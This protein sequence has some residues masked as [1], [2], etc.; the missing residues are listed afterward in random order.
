MGLYYALAQ[1]TLHVC[2][3]NDATTC[4]QALHMQVLSS[5]LDV[6][7]P[8]EF[9]FGQLHSRRMLDMFL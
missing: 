2:V 8:A 9:L 1:K 3:S 7:V 5:T 6:V 4:T